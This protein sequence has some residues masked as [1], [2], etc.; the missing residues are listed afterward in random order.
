MFQFVVKRWEILSFFSNFN[1]N[2]LVQPTTFSTFFLCDVFFFFFIMTQSSPE[3]NQSSRC[4]SHVVA[5]I[6]A[7]ENLFNFLIVVSLCHPERNFQAIEDSFLPDADSSSPLSEL[8]FLI[9]FQEL[10]KLISIPDSRV[11]ETSKHENR[12]IETPTHKLA[13]KCWENLHKIFFTKLF[14]F[15]A[16]HF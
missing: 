12:V 3:F 16:M 15:H 5:K 7:N 13:L 4:C 6:Y 8:T 11:G 9:A 1:P 10:S 2:L 14:H